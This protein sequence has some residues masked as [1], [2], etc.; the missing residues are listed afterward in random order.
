MPCQV[1]T[2]LLL[3]AWESRAC[4]PHG[5][6]HCRSRSPRHYPSRKGAHV[7][8]LH[9][10][11]EEDLGDW[12]RVGLWPLQWGTQNGAGSLLPCWT[13][14]IVL[15]SGFGPALP[16]IWGWDVFHIPF[17]SYYCNV[18]FIDSESSER[19]VAVI[20]MK[21]LLP[22]QIPTPPPLFFFLDRSSLYSAC[23]PL[24]YR[25]LLVSASL[26]LGLKVCTITPSL[27]QAS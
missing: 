27:W 2:I 9:Y 15:S 4:H 11:S 22:C 3:E 1:S 17:V 16:S 12:G 19:C 24:T 25:D 8:C 14:A 18:F 26:V 23:W 10:T 13:I 5:C 6:P 21:P 7:G 20:T